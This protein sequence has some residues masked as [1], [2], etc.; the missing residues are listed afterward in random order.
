MYKFTDIAIT[1]KC[2]TRKYESIEIKL[3]ATITES[4][5]IINTIENIDN[6]I[7]EYI[8]KQREV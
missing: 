2:I 5:H 4:E 7:M 1:R 8:N 3:E 6:S